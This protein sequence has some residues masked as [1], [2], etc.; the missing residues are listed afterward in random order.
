[1]KKVDDTADLREAIAAHAEAIAAGEV[2]VAETFAHRDPIGA[3]REVAGEI[4]RLAGP[5]VIEDLALAQIGAQYISMLRIVGAG[6]Y[7]RVL[8][9]WRREVDGK[10]VIAGVE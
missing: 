1:M 3:Y 8:Y 5:L 10:W 7:R 4:A 9:R 6:A 2:A